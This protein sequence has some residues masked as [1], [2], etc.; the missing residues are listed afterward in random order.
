[1]TLTS[2]PTAPPSATVA[3]IGAGRLG[4][5]LAAALR[6]AEF[7]V[8]GPLGRDDGIPRTDIALLCV[9]DAEI[10]RAAQTARRARLIG[11]VSGATGL[12]DVDFSVHPL[13]TFTGT[14]GPEIFRGIGAAIAGRA[15]EGRATAE[16]IA[17]AL[18][19][20]PFEVDDA[21]RAGYHAAASLASNLALA[22]LDAAEQVALAAGIRHPRGLLAPLVERTVANWTHTGAGAALTGPLVRGDQATVDRQRDA[23]TAANAELAPL[24]DELVARARDISRSRTERP[25]ART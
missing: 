3:V 23:V 16:Q 11:H 25:E 17:L 18:G 14:E 15:A 7:T 12:D 20:R 24:F 21:H 19:A 9:P 10:P 4:G 13:Q 1:M 22:V 2:A 5:V 6:A 8:T